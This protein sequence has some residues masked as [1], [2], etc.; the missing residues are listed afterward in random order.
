MRVFAYIDPGTTGLIAQFA[1]AGLTGVVFY[2]RSRFRKSDDGDESGSV[3]IELTAPNEA[4]T[5]EDRT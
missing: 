5:S 1:A 3:A 4:E 2:F